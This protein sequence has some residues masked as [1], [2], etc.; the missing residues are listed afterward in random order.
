M[1]E[2]DRHVTRTGEDYADAMQA[3]LPIGHA[4]PR[5]DGSVLMR[6]VRGLTKI[7]GNFEIRASTLLERESDPRSTIEMLADWERNWGLPD[8]CWTTPQT[9][10]ARQKFLVQRMTMLGGPS[11]EFFIRIAE[12]LGY[13]ITITEYAPWMFGVS[14]VGETDDGHSYWRWEIG[15]PEIRYY[16]T[17]HIAGQSVLWWRYGSAIIGVDPHCRFG[18]AEDLECIFE[19]WKPAHTDVIFDYSGTQAIGKGEA[20]GVGVTI[21]TFKGDAAGFGWTIADASS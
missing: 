17:V 1:I 18:R 9:I 5:D 10:E 21:K 6:V 15:P 19:R 7:W 16:W 11:R 14:E 4:W 2:P 3:L 13:T 12:E 8:P 20:H